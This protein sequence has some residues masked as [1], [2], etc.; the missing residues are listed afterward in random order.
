MLTATL[1]VNSLAD[2]RWVCGFPQRPEWLSQNLP[3][4][5]FV[6][7][8]DFECGL[9]EAGVSGP[10]ADDMHP[11]SMFTP[12]A[13]P[14]NNPD[15]HGSYVHCTTIA[16]DRFVSHRLR[17]S[18]KL[19]FQQRERI[20]TASEMQTMSDS[21]RISGNYAKEIL[22]TLILRRSMVSLIPFENGTP[23]IDI[24]VMRTTTTRLKF[25]NDGSKNLYTFLVD[26]YHEMQ[27]SFSPSPQQT[28]AKRHRFSPRWRYIR[29][30]SLSPLLAYASFADNYSTTKL[31]GEDAAA[32][33]GNPHRIMVKTL[34]SRFHEEF[35]DEG[36]DYYKQSIAGMT[37]DDLTLAIE[38]SSPKLGWIKNRLQK[39]VMVGKEKVILWVYWPLSQ[40]LV[41]EVSTVTSQ[42]KSWRGLIKY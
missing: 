24:P 30:V 32:D 7:R 16:W 31:F 40:W 29:L 23:I 1:M 20:L 42:K 37:D 3:Q 26:N 12:V 4:D 34:L 17:D 35:P 2:L 28:S 27:K 5:T 8:D 22:H 9:W 11:K 21:Q 38:F 15:H 39:L 36:L 41:R 13:N 18:I 25:A 14:F 10:S 19:Q 6:N 33:D